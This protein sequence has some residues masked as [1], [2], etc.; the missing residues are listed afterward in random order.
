MPPFLSRRAEHARKNIIDMFEM[1]AEV[2]EFF[3]RGIAQNFLDLGV[4]F[5]QRQKLAFAAP[6]R[7]RIALDERIGILS[8]HA[9]LRQGEQ[10]ALRMDEAA[11]RI[12]IFC[13]RAG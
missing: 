12:E 11:E 2:E 8:A 10:H 13:I 5:Q 6:D 4:L 9:L 7:H 3:E 1:I